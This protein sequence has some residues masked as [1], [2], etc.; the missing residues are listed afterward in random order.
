MIRL[1]TKRFVRK[2]LHLPRKILYLFNY[3]TKRLEVRINYHKM[4]NDVFLFYAFSFN[5]GEVRNKI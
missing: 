5:N 4:V 3:I 2:R 1:K